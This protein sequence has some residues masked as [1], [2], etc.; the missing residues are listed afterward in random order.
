MLTA[1]LAAMAIVMAVTASRPGLAAATAAA[2]QGGS[3]NQVSGA[4]QF[5]GGDGVTPA[6]WTGGGLT[7]PACGPIP[8]DGGP[9][10]PV[11]P[12]PG[13]L[14]TPGYQCVEFSERYLY[15]RYGVTIG[16]PT[17]G[18]QVAAHYAAAYP[19]LFMIVKNGTPH[20][21]PVAGDVLSLSTVPGFDS[22]AGGHTAVVQSGSVNAAGNGSVTIVEEN[23]VPGGIQVLPVSNWY[24]TYDGFPYLEWLTTVGLLVT[25]P[26][27]PSAQVSQGYTATLTATGGPGPY[28]WAVTLGSLPPG[29]A[30]SR[31]GLLSG[32][33]TAATASGGDVVG[34][35]PFTVTATDASGAV[36]VEDLQL[37][38]TGS[39]DAFYYDS[40]AGSL[41]DARWE[42]SRWVFTTID[43]AGSVLAGHT[44]GNVGRAASAV[45]ID[46]QPMVFYPDATTG[47][48][49]AAWR[50][51][52][53]WRFA[54]LDGPGSTVPG[55]TAGH[56]GSA[57]SAVVAGGE[58]EVF[59]YDA[60][61]ASVRFARET[62]AG[63]QLATLDGPGS[64]LYQHTWHHVG[65]ALS[66]LV[67]GGQPQVYYYDATAGTLHRAWSNGSRW[68]F[69]TIDGPAALL[70][71]HTGGRVGSAVSATL[72]GGRPDVFYYDAS[73]ASLRYA[74]LTASG[75]R[76]W[77]LDGAGST[78]AR[79]TAD[80][81]GSAVAVTQLKGN[82]QV[83]YYD[84]TRKSLRH[85]LWTGSTWVL[86]TLDGAGSV[87]AG[88]DT[89]QV[90]S[91]LSVTETPVGPQVYYA[92][93]T[94][95]SLRH[96][97]W[98][99]AGWR[100]ETLDGPGSTVPGHTGA[101]VGGSVAVTLY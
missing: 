25:T 72:I 21:A 2:S 58:P 74:R 77:T 84:A 69:L 36:A 59:Y 9:K 1:G 29:L 32:A 46:G 91:A 18:D 3:C 15:Y 35:W 50:S 8:N 17:N 34:S 81:V 97:W 22:A 70:A 86:E 43:G 63:W 67:A 79:H 85:A 54:T 57:V 24:V 62:A 19:A 26:T 28:R 64:V 38:V 47:S 16:V 41:R 92:D 4:Y 82:A 95:G 87:I 55:H 30:L 20:R 98:T 66:A 100:F 14:W 52:G 10:T 42:G 93:A 48:L 11:Y 44:A 65:S 96:A 12:Y 89:D 78:L 51:G 76:F 80:S 94:A 60:T 71:G 7:V 56:V 61:D 75:W 101:R 39:P 90:G 33:V 45:E 99:P 13:A 68:F 53:S 5:P 6:A 23:A 88:H 31:A 40:A 37:A 83:Y 27:L 73:N 49:R